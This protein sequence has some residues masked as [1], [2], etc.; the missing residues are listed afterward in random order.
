M[1]SSSEAFQKE[2]AA[3]VAANDEAGIREFIKKAIEQEEEWMTS[4]DGLSRM[5]T[6]EFLN[7]HQKVFDAKKKEWVAFNKHEHEF[8]L[9]QRKESYDTIYRSARSIRFDYLIRTGWETN[10]AMKEARKRG[11]KTAVAKHLPED[12]GIWDTKEG[13]LAMAPMISS[14]VPFGEATSKLIHSSA[15]LQV[16]HLTTIEFIP[17]IVK[18]GFF[19]GL[20]VTTFSDSPVVPM[21]IPK[22]SNV[23]LLAFDIEE[24]FLHPRVS[25]NGLLSL[26]KKALVD[27]LP[28]NLRAKLRKMEPRKGD[29]FSW[30]SGMGVISR[31]L[32]SGKNLC[33]VPPSRINK[34]E[35]L[36]QTI[37]LV[38]DRGLRTP[39]DKLRKHLGNIKNDDGCLIVEERQEDGTLVKR[40]VSG[41]HF[42]F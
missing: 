26:G 31:L 42:F 12:I 41:I 13:F 9:V 20:H 10:E 18:Y 23:V 39:I 2:F 25:K 11:I 27:G 8:S 33:M 14:S 36:S 35:T 1:M 37:E 34:N 19:S 6:V 30:S 28:N 17:L 24:D 22:K 38:N 32:S 15:L 7:R 29:G 4:G 5:S 16:Y 40:R 3:L 21:D